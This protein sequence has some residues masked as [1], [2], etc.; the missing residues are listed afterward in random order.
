LIEQSPEIYLYASLLEAS[1]YIG[2]DSKID[3]WLSA[4]NIGVTSLNATSNN[5]QYGELLDY[6]YYGGP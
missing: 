2:E 4:Y 5:K 6:T 3:M 1:P